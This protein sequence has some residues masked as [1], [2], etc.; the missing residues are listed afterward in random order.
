MHADHCFDWEPVG[1]KF[2]RNSENSLLMRSI[3]VPLVLSVS[4][5]QP[6]VLVFLNSVALLTAENCRCGAALC[7]D[8]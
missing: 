4:Y 6:N 7:I 1:K 8:I 5:S 2:C 3:L